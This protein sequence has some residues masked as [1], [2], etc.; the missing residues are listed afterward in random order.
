MAK[1]NTTE[2][3][4]TP[5]R[6]DIAGKS[7]FI[8]SNA[9]KIALF[10]AVI[11]LVIRLYR[12]GFLSLW[13][14]EYMHALAAMK[15]Q[16]T[17]GENNGILL[18]WM[19][20]ILSSVFGNS[21]FVMRFPVALLGA[22][23]IPAVYVLGRDI[24]NYK[25]GL[26]AAVLV[27]IS[28]Y[29][30]FWSRVQRPYGMVA[31]FYVP[32]LLSFWLML[33]RKPEK[34]S[35][36]ARIGINPKYL[37][38]VV[39]A[40]AL[41]MLSQLLCFLFFFTAGFYGTFMAIEGW[42]TR[43]FSPVKLNAYNL[44]FYINIL[45]CVFMF[46]TFGNKVMRPMMELF[47]PANIVTLILPDMKAI[48]A[49][50]DGDK[51][52]KCFDTYLD[53]LEADF[54]Y[55][56]LLGWAGFALSLLRNRKTG[57]FLIAAFVVPFLLLSFIFTSTSHAK[58][59]SFIYPIFL[60]SASYSLYFIAF[61]ILPRFSKSFNETS[62]S[63]LNICAAAFV[64][65]A[66]SFMQRKEIKAMLVT[67]AHGNVVDKRLAEIHFVNWKQP[68]EYI[69]DHMK[70]N[71]VVMATV[72][73]APRYYLNMDNDSV[74]WFRQMQLDG[75]TKTYVPRKPETNKRSAAT[76]EQ[77]VK[78][79]NE[80]PRGWLLADY[81]FDN[82]LTDPRAKEFAEQN[83]TYHFDACSDGAVKVFSWDKSKPKAYQS[84]FVIELGKNDNQQASQP[85]TVNINKASLPPVAFLQFLTQGIDSDNEAYVII[86]GDKQ[87]AI[88]PNGRPSQIE[89]NRVKV[90][91]AIFKEGQNK[92]QFIYNTEEGNGDETKGFVIYNFDLSN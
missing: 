64:I 14:D 35:F 41:S 6:K 3:V 52:A 69:R 63:Y 25:V 12:L 8:E 36:L 17:H 7:G 76:F 81:Y 23:L 83:F 42:M 74:V 61:N 26:M 16:F 20:T 50:L 48:L 82:A 70:P 33:E 88:T 77:F 21:E 56:H 38:L 73:A 11:G 49:T 85:F 22:A 90:D 1:K 79:Y 29:L 65:L 58:Y 4:R 89:S 84:A 51:W 75:K 28:L 15:G 44:L 86:N 55:V 72:K 2:K 13:V 92:I 37:L 91:P 32:L 27:T 60:I 24:S 9:M 57:Y 71:D 80:N 62:R 53:V 43:K 10:L 67:E 78:T 19:N 66:F 47:L 87:V 54:K 30:I 39:A 18:T 40:L 34:D 59:I 5:V 31:T 46:T 45:L 68:C